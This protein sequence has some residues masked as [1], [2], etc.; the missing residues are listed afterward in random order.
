[1]CLR[2][3]KIEESGGSSK[4]GTSIGKQSYGTLG[5]YPVFSDT[6]YK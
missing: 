2:N 1:M 6:K 3:W 5:S 4:K